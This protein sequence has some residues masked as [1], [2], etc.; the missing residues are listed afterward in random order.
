MS[1]KT[2]EHEPHFTERAHPILWRLLD[3][4]LLAAVL[5]AGWYYRGYLLKLWGTI[6]QA[7]FPCLRPIPYEIGSVDSRFGLTDKQVADVLKKAA[8]AWE[9]PVGRDLFVADG[10]TAMKINLVY[11]YRQ[12]ATDKLRQMGYTIKSDQASYDSLKASYLKAKAKFDQDKVAYESAKSSFEEQRAAFETEVQ[13]WNARGGA[14][15]GQFEK[16][17]AERDA[18]NAA[19]D[20][21]NQQAG[22]LNA[23]VAE[24]NAMVTALNALAAKLNIKA[25]EFNTVV[26][27]RGE[28]FQEGQY[29]SSDGVQT[30]DIYEFD[31]VEQLTSVLVHEFGHALGLEHSDNP[32]DVMYRLNEGAGGNGT[33]SAGDIA[34]LKARCGIK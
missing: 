33:V 19:A 27:S 23:E 12:Q 14:P 2:Q 20:S 29:R 13:Y 28:E 18:V 3:L 26:G 30:I 11:D 16:L 25:D 24:V 17:S 1:V 7:Y 34:A 21:L 10:D 6:E 31:S 5:A 8:D 15:A 22:A 9:K 4:L 32:K